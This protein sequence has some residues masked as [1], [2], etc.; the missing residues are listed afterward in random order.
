MNEKF[1]YFVLKE[2]CLMTIGCITFK[3]MIVMIFETSQA[4]LEDICIGIMLKI[5]CLLC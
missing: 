4:W 2:S 1:S 5:R 3:E